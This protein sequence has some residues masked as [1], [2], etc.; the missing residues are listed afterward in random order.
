MKIKNK[1][2][3]AIISI[4][5]IISMLT[6]VIAQTVDFSIPSRAE[7][8]PVYTGTKFQD[9][10]DKMTI[11][12]Q[13]QAEKYPFAWWRDTT[14]QN[15][16][17]EHSAKNYPND[18]IVAYDNTATSVKVLVW[19]GQL[20]TNVIAIV[21]PTGNTIIGCG[22]GANAAKRALSAFAAAV[23]DF[24]VD[25]RSIIY[26]EANKEVYWGGTEWRGT[27]E[28]TIPVLVYG[29]ANIGD[30]GEVY[31]AVESAEV[32]HELYAYGPEI[33]Y[34][35]NGNL[36]TGSEFAYN[37]YQ[38]NDELFIANRFIPT[39]TTIVSGGVSIR[40]IPTA[41]EDAGLAVYLP[42]EKILVLGELFGEYFPP[43]RSIIGNT[44]MPP[45][46]WIK[47]LD[48]M[49]K[50]NPNILISMHSL[51]TT[52]TSPI[53]PVEALTAQKNALTFVHTQVVTL[54]NQMKSED[55]IVNWV[56]LP[57][58]LASSPY[59]H[60]HPST[61]ECAVRAIYHYYLGW[62]NWKADSLNNFSEI[63]QA[64]FLIDLAGGPT[65]ALATAKAYET[66]HTT[67]GVQK[68]IVLSGA[69]RLVAPS[70]GADLIY[71]TALRKMA[72]SQESGELRNFYLLTAQRIERTMP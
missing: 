63:Q 59:N 35:V 53:T 8:D 45:N 10:Y 51:P 20:G 12:T 42:T 11:T 71:T 1:T 6:P 4:V 39:E 50:L 23:P 31:K 65:K 43:Y 70:H 58:E 56:K 9:T 18:I 30:I 5:L 2:I 21:G 41:P 64:Q 14:A 7:F 60:E 34:G 13:L 47:V 15:S 57:D 24:Q 25:L 40:L 61:V 68:A 46:R 49:I 62:F 37:P 32:Q 66:D 28:R 27:F 55:D 69:L 19:A 44:N 48:N 26:T 38:P 52:I 33:P 67:L 16:L 29:Y 3:L 36:G 72:Y 54:I 17:W 22:G